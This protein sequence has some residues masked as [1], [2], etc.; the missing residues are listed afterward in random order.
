MR[1]LMR[2]A[3]AIAVV[4]ISL[5]GF[6]AGTI[7]SAD[8]LPAHD[9][10][11]SGAAAVPDVGATAV[12]LAADDAAAV[13]QTPAPAELI[14]PADDDTEP[15]VDAASGP[16]DPQ[17]APT[18]DAAP[19][20]LAAVTPPALS[21][22]FGPAPPSEAAA[23]AAAASDEPVLAPEKR[24]WEEARGGYFGSRAYVR[25]RLAG[26][27]SRVLTDRATLPAEDPAFLQRLAADTWR[28]MVAL[29]DRENGLPV[30]HVW[31]VSTRAPP[32]N[33]A[34]EECLRAQSIPPE[35]IEACERA[36]TTLPPGVR[37]QVGDYT[38]VTTIGMQLAAIVGARELGLVSPPDALAMATRIVDTLATLETWNGVFYN[39]YDTT[40]LERTS[41]FLSF[42]DSAW[43]AAGLMI[44]RSAFPELYTRASALIEATNYALFYD[45]ER[46]LMTHGYHVNR[47]TRAPY[48][49]GAF[50]TEARL[51]T[52]IAIGKGEVPPDPW[53]EMVRTWP[54]ACIGQTMIPVTNDLEEIGG[55][56]V[57]SGLYEWGGVRYVPSWGG[58]M[59]EA[60]MPTLVL[61]EMRYARHSLGRNGVA[62]AR[63]QRE[64]AVEE[65]RYP[66]WGMSP[67]M[68]PGSEVYGEYGARVVGS[69]G[70]TDGVVTPHAGALA[71]LVTPDAA[72][73]NLKELAQRYELYGDFGF[74]DAV[75]PESGEVGAVYL[76]LDQAML[77]LAAVN[78]LTEGS[79]QDRFAAD[80]L[81]APILPMLAAERFF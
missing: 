47:Q 68:T 38:N 46:R 22:P 36:L 39:Y 72:L 54:A 57:S 40:T 56:Q 17:A 33:G 23:A 14:P 70:Y 79:I 13:Q 25:A 53:Y 71:L 41:N 18:S 60:L 4:A 61:D 65:L 9:A 78:H 67:S 42:V 51:G 12:P 55:Y 32:Q 75:K 44:T 76:A 21:C 66:V 20:P 1:L 49:Y 37:P 77:F 26:L 58:S 35:E 27:P 8:E 52:L 48:H 45:P 81:I 15:A 73:A 24:A 74:Y 31:V 64:Y 43:L 59:F 28:G 63:V 3:R 29:T 50:Y 2:F 62:H 11:A 5:V 16:I 34:V 69:R 6:A 10:A 30:D 19:T 7:A 80:P